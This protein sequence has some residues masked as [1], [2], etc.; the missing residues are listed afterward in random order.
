M[1]SE[2]NE[3]RVGEKIKSAARAMEKIAPLIL[4]MLAQI[5]CVYPDS[6]QPLRYDDGGAEYFWSDYYPNGLAVRFTPPASRWKI[7][8][9]L[10]YGFI[11]DKGEKTFMVEVR[12]DDFNTVFRAYYYASR[13]F[14]NATLDWVRI[15]LPNIIVKGDFYVCIYPMLEL[16]GTQLW[17]AVDND[18]ISDKSF[19]VDCYRQEVRKYSEGSAMIRVE[20]EEA[21]D[22][23]EIILHSISIGENLKLLFKVVAPSNVTEVKA[24]LQIGFLAEDCPVMHRDGLYEVIVDWSKLAGLKEPARLILSA[25]TLNMTASLTVKLNGTFFSTY[26][27]LRDENTLLKIMLNSSK[28]GQEALK[29][30]LENEEANVNTLR[31]LLEVYKKRWLDEA[32]RNERL[33]GELNIIRLLTAS[34]IVLTIFLLI[35]TLRKKLPTDLKSSRASKGG[36]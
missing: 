16:S 10:I 34:L 3:L 19:L 25:K 20:G 14:K 22:F 31:S 1:R 36:E 17:I 8:S 5:P 27:Q 15:S 6:S 29:R 4:L 23:I 24:T 30:K 35:A 11:I 26:F 21:I 33:S 32:K 13:H 2:A 18:T 9:I 28:L 7:T 12:D